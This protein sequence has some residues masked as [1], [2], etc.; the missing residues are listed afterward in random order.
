MGNASVSPQRR[1]VDG[2]CRPSGRELDERSER[3][4]ISDP[5]DLAYVPFHVGGDVAGVPELSVEPAVV[6]ARVCTR[7]QGLKERV[8]RIVEPLELVEREGQEM[9]DGGPPGEGLRD[10]LGQAEL[11]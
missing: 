7:Q 8:G 4:E 1:Q 10:G 6:H 2:L 5:L 3:L 9:E 11:V